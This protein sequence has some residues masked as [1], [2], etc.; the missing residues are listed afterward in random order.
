MTAVYLVIA[1][2]LRR[3]PF[4]RRLSPFTAYA[5]GWALYAEKLAREHGFYKDDPF[6]C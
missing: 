4:F 5:E 1:Q 6:D 2:E 3:V